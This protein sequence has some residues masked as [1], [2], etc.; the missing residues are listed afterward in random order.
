MSRNLINLFCLLV[1][2]CLGVV[3]MSAQVPAPMPVPD[4]KLPKDPKI[5]TLPP[6]P[7]GHESPGVFEGKDD[8][9]TEKSSLVDGNVAIKLCVA[10][11]DL[12]INGWQRNEVR[13][14]VKQGREFRMKPLEKSAAGKVN[15]LWIGS[16]VEGRPGPGAECLAGE[17][18]EIDAPVGT[19]LDIN[20][21][22][23]SNK[24]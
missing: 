2:L 11:G 12:K 24:V 5:K 22:E 4:K 21:R 1:A 20:R 3:S 19:S 17:R 14:F 7:P 23:V 10:H 13:V 8:A 6:T 15:W 9:T 18:L 16:I